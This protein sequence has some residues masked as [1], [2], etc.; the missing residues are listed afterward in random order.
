MK[1]DAQHAAA[2]RSAAADALCR[3]VARVELARRVLKVRAGQ[4]ERL[5][6][7]QQCHG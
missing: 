5:L 6:E 4:L 3:A 7:R 1:L 2:D